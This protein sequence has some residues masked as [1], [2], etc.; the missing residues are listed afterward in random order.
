MSPHVVIRWKPGLPK[1]HDEFFFLMTNLDASALPIRNQRMTIEQLFRAHKRS[2]HR[3]V[4]RNTRIQ[5]ADRFDRLLLILATPTCCSWTWGCASSVV[6][7]LERYE[8][9]SSGGCNVRQ[10]DRCFVGWELPLY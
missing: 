2:R 8:I 10:G 5:R 9:A 4:V 6:L 1:K 7:Y 3:F